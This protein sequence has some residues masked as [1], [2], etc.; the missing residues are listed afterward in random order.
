[1]ELEKEIEIR[2]KKVRDRGITQEDM[3]KEN[4]DGYSKESW[5]DGEIIILEKTKKERQRL[6]KEVEA[7]IDELKAEYYRAFR[8]IPPELNK[9]QTMNQVTTIMW[10]RI[11]DL[12]SRLF[13][14][15]K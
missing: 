3:D 8:G 12:K 15:E 14:E 7:V 1:M 6:A 4:D 13:R 9:Q 2:K 10:T 11:D 5:W